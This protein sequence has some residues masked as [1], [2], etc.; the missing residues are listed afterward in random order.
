MMHPLLKWIF[1][2]DF[3]TKEQLHTAG[4]WLLYFYSAR[5]CHVFYKNRLLAELW[6]HEYIVIF[7]LKKSYN[8]LNNENFPKIQNVLK[9]GQQN[10]WKSEMTQLTIILNIFS[11]HTITMIHIDVIIIFNICS[12]LHILENCIS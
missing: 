1:S 9:L 2:F 5:G 8:V 12:H 7:R 4:T 3:H 10:L 11:H 6:L